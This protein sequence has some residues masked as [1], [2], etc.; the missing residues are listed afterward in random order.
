MLAKTELIV[1]SMRPGRGSG[2][3][4]EL[5]VRRRRHD[6]TFDSTT[7]A[8]RYRRLAE[9]IAGHNRLNNNHEGGVGSSC[10]LGT[11]DV[12]LARVNVS[13]ELVHHR[14]SRRSRIGILG[15]TGVASF[16]SFPWCIQITYAT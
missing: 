3:G 10:L 14:Y 15:P 2:P 8:A 5:P 1:L 16:I 13:W 12:V 7:Q 6:A 11:C 9:E 4:E